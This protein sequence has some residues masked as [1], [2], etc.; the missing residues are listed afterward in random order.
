LEELSGH[1]WKR[2]HINSKG[3]FVPPEKQIK[4]EHFESE[5][6]PE[7]AALLDWLAQKNNKFVFGWNG[8]QNIIVPNSWN[9]PENRPC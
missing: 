5:A 3:K 6:Q 2:L 4:L 9:S 8:M 1:A 7:F